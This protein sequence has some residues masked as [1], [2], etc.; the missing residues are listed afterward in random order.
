MKKNKLSSWINCS[1]NKNIVIDSLLCFNIDK[2]KFVTAILAKSFYT[3]QQIIEDNIG[4]DEMDALYFFYGVRIKEKWYFFLG[5]TCYLPRKNYQSDPHTPLSFAKLHEIAMK[6]VF[7]GYLIKKKKN[8]GLWKNLFDPEY[9]YV[10][11]DN[12]FSELDRIV[13]GVREQEEKY[14]GRSFKSTEEYMDWFVKATVE[15][16]WQRK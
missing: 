8:V 3:Q 12:F 13:R 4:D 16:N 7:S 14:H 5:A 2:N 9:E 6:E 11:N 15:A 1:I 10:I